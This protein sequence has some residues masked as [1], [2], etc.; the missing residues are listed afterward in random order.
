[1]ERSQNIRQASIRTIATNLTLDD[2][3]IETD[4]TFQTAGVVVGRAN[5]CPNCGT[6]K[7]NGNTCC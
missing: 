5:T 6:I 2:R 4:P 7:I 1:M 3:F